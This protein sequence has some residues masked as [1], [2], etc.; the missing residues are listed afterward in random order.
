[1]NRFHHEIIPN[2]AFDIQSFSQSRRNVRE[3]LKLPLDKKIVLFASDNLK[4]PRKGIH[5]LFHA[6]RQLTEKNKILL[7]GIGH[8]AEKPSDL[9]VEYTGNVSDSRALSEYFYSSD[10]F[11]TPTVAENSPLVVIE[12]L[13]CGT[14]VIGSCV[15]GIPDLI[16]SQNGL[17]F[18]TGDVKAIAESL[19]QVL[20]EKNFDRQKIMSAA[21]K[22]HKPVTVAQKYKYQIYNRIMSQDRKKH[23]STSES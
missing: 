16:N 21:L 7:L 13:C 2:P 5:F 23:R 9:D 6:V 20:F 1:M 10:V 3:E 4:N 22:V 12:S 18:P 15:G 8:K 17:L 19:Q 14:P 11:V